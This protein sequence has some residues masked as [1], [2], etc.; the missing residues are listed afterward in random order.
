ML[1]KSM[2][3]R[4]LMTTIVALLVAQSAMA[5]DTDPTPLPAELVACVAESDVL[6]RLSCFDRAMA[7]LLAEDSSNESAPPPAPSPAAERSAATAAAAP[8]SVPDAA[9]AAAAPVAPTASPAP[10]ASPSA[11]PAAPAPVA[12][13]AAPASPAAAEES[14]AASLGDAPAAAS[15]AEAETA[16]ASAEDRRGLP[17]ERSEDIVATVVEIRERPYGEL[18][19][20]LDNGQVWEQKHRDRRFRLQVGEEVTISKGMISGYRL[21]GRSNNSIQVSRMK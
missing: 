4:T 3:R 7:T 1:E 18:I 19:I 13:R 20:F 11:A 10:L 14:P 12:A 8:V 6:A 9:V 16:P 5:D 21:S 15:V 2:I 17:A